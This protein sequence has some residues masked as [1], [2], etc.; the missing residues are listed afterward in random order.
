MGCSILSFNLDFYGHPKKDHGLIRQGQGNQ[1]FGEGAHRRQCQARKLWLIAQRSRH[2]RITH[3]HESAFINRCSPFVVG[4]ANE[5]IAIA[6][7]GQPRCDQGLTAL[8]EAS[9]G[10]FRFCVKVAALSKDSKCAF[11]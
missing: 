4:L 10:G 7:F 3:C 2:L 11:I 5:N 9:M 6:L 1:D 8:M